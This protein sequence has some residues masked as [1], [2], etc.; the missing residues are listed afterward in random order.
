M[1]NILLISATPRSNHELAKQIA[2]EAPNDV[3]TAIIVL[4]ELDIPL[5]S[6]SAEAAGIPKAIFELT[7]KM[8]RAGAYV[9]VAPEYNGSLPPVLNNAIAWISRSTKD[10][11]HNFSGKFAVV[12]TMSGGGGNKVVQAMRT[13]L[14]HLGTTVHS[15]ALVCSSQKALNPESANRV[16]SDLSHWL[17]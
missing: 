10:W 3:E 6:P 1:K 2:A 13:Q 9:F 14:E 8:S 4:E 12:A 15:H 11:R 5:Y 17:R 16:M 7:E